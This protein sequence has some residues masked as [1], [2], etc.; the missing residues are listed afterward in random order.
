MKSK[1][2]ASA[3]KA[4]PPIATAKQWR[5]RRVALLKREKQI[6]KAS[7]RVAAQRRRLPMVKVEKDYVFDTLKGKRSLRDLFNGRKQLIVY[8]F[9]FDPSQGLPGL[10]RLRR[11]AW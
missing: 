2:P 9:M 3:P 8:H 5:A 11:R 10:H 7:D 1:K 4:H 6:T